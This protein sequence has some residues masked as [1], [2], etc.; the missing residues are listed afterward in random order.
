VALLTGAAVAG[1]AILLLYGERLLRLW[2]HANLGIGRG[3]L[4]AISAWIVTQAL[5]RVP[6][7]LLNGLLLIRFQTVVFAIATAAALGLK[8][9][10]ARRLGV[11]GILWGTS[12]AVL[13]IVVPAGLWRIWRWAKDAGAEGVTRVAGGGG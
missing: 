1:S 7:L 8:F 9:A 13:V 11:A 10:L 12:I 6:N 5:V 2:L 4:W 3:L